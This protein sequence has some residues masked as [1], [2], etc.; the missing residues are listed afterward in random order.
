M[1]RGRA[2]AGKTTISNALGKRLNIAVIHKDDIYDTVAKSITDR[3]VRNKICFDI[4]RNILQSALN[5]QAHII[6]DFGHNNL[7]DVEKLQLWIESREGELKPILC[8]CDDDGI[9]KERLNQRK[10]N[11]LPNQ[12]LTDIEDLKAHYANMRTGVL[13]GE[14]VLDTTIS[15]DILLDKAVRYVNS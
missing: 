3:A 7:D 12:A 10:L 6:I 13:P 2:G 8:V 1:F 15:I 5:C 14:L 9:W 4:L 11:P